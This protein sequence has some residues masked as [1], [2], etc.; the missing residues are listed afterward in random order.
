LVEVTWLKPSATKVPSLTTTAPKGP[1]LP[2]RIMSSESAMA[3]RMWV[4]GVSVMA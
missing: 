3:R 4:S 1:P 2:D